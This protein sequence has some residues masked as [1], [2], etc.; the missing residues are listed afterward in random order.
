[1]GKLKIVTDELVRELFGELNGIMQILADRL[2]SE[3]AHSLVVTADGENKTCRFSLM[4]R[5]GK[6]LSSHKIDFPI[7]SAVV[8]IKVD[9]AGENLIFTLNNGSTTTAPIG[10]IVR[11]LAT[12]EQLNAEIEARKAADKEIE[13]KLTTESLARVN[14]NAELK[15]GIEAEKTARQTA[16]EQLSEKIAT[17]KKERTEAFAELPFFVGDDGY[18]YGKD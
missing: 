12:T 1:M 15:S 16:V 6:I 9:E 8:N 4:A 5:D 7:E 14:A 3:L 2:T 18:I 11:G 17:E 10:S 13:R